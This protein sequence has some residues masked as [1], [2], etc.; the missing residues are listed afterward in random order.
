MLK[1]APSIVLRCMLATA[2]VAGATA[3][4]GGDGSDD[5]RLYQT[6]PKADGL[7]DAS[8]ANLAHLGPT[9]TDRGVNFG[10]YSKHATRL[11][12]LL[13]ED[14]ESTLPTRQFEMTRFGDVWNLF[15]EGIGAGQHYG[16]VAW[17]PN[18][19]F[20]PKWTPGHIDGF[21]SAADPA[22]NRFDPNKLRPEP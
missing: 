18:W 9:L 20:D 21:Q 1:R 19:P 16:F 10:V 13:F 4:C 12:I 3:G 14:P 17:G 2:V 5:V 6:H 7:T 8:I 11:D 22:G 15:V